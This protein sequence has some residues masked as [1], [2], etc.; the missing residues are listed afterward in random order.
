M[1]LA[2]ALINA[3]C[4]AGG[5]VVKSDRPLALDSDIVNLLEID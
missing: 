2:S 5:S 1:R 3:I 4:Q